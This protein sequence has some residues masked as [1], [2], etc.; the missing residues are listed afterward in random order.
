MPLSGNPL[1]DC[2][3]KLLIKRGKTIDKKSPKS[4]FLNDV[5]GLLHQTHQNIIILQGF[6]ETNKKFPGQ[7]S[8]NSIQHI[9]LFVQ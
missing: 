4:F 6:F 7:V 2:S 3:R 5:I 8:R 9:V 1:I